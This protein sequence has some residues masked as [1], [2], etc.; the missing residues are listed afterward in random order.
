MNNFVKV[1]PRHYK[2]VLEAMATAEK[3]GTDV[4]QAVMSVTM[5]EVK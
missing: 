3:S 2:K 4:T 1:M 5:G